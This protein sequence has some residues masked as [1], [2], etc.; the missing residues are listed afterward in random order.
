M[1][2][3]QDK[4]VFVWFPNRAKCQNAGV[5]AR[6]P[7]AESCRRES[8]LNIVN[9]VP[10]PGLFDV[11]LW[12]L[13]SLSGRSAACKDLEQNLQASSVKRLEQN[14]L[15]RPRKAFS[16]DSLLISIHL[17]KFLDKCTKLCSM[18]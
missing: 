10:I 5:M 16:R 17:D 13:G 2:D 1:C 11:L 12:D 14:Q 15:G 7:E 18:E 8:T 9:V 3:S 4:Q 6:F